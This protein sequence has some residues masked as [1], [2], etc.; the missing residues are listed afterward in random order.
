M[1]THKLRLILIF[2]LFLVAVIA[3]VALV[4]VGKDDGTGFGFLSG[5]AS[6]L[7]PALLDAGAEQQKRTRQME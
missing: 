5:V 4:I 2:V 6:T 3:L 1:V 7:L